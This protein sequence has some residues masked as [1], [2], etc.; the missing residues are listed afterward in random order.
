MNTNATQPTD[1]EMNVPDWLR[2]KRVWPRS[3]VMALANLAAQQA[4]VLSRPDYC[5]YLDEGEPCGARQPVESMCPRCA[6]IQAGED[7]KKHHA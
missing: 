3:H 1:A 7:F 5:P 6:A 4:E 2:K